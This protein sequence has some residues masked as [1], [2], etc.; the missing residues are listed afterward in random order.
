LTISIKRKN[1]NLKGAVD[2]NIENSEKHADSIPEHFKNLRGSV[3]NM[4]PYWD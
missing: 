3:Y 2:Y 1:I 4:L